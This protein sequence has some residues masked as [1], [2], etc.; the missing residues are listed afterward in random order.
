MLSGEPFRAVA[1]DAQTS[2]AAASRHWR[3]HVQPVMRDAVPVHLSEFA[4]RLVA[5]ADDASDLRELG[6]LTG[7]HR[8][9]LQAG[10]AEREALADLINRL[11][12]DDTEAIEEIE[13]CRAFVVAVQ[14]SVDD[15]PELAERLAR[16]LDRQGQD[17]LAAGVRSL[18]DVRPQLRAVPPKEIRR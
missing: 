18:V 11:G 14:R 5:V 12:V 3:L 10:R 2:V 17:E 1:S 9:A 15:V 4:H 8:L 16:E 7:D 13:A 6:R